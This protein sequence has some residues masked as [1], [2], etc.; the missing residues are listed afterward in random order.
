VV[1]PHGSDSNSVTA[2]EINDKNARENR[3]KYEKG[4]EERRFSS[5]SRSMSPDGR[6]S[7]GDKKSPGDRDRR[8]GRSK[9]SGNSGGPTADLFMRVS[10]KLS[11]R[12]SLTR[13]HKR[14]NVTTETTAQLEI[15]R[16]LYGKDSSVS[17]REIELQSTDLNYTANNYD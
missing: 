1:P 13:K 12:L 16:Y 17:S 14:P 11:R 2:D 10:G 6:K 15:E 5:G 9:S 7:P 3:K 4:P 8:R